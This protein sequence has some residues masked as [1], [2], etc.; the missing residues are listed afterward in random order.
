V[1]SAPRRLYFLLGQAQHRLRKCADRLS[2]ETLRVSSPQ[3]GALY[4]IGA[5]DGC[6]QRDI[7]EEFGQHESA[8]TGMLSRLQQGGFIERR[9]SEEDSRVRTVFITT[10]GRE[11]LTAADQMLWNFNRRLVRGFTKEEI[12]VVGRFLESVVTRIDEDSF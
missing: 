2:M 6:L 8:V 5:H 3:I 4:F 1:P 7:A 9:E 12:E 11:T 10:R